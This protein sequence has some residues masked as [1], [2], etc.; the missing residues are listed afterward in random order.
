MKTIILFLISGM[1]I[2]FSCTLRN[3]KQSVVITIDETKNIEPIEKYDIEKKLKLEK[4]L[5]ENNIRKSFSDT[6]LNIDYNC[7]IGQP[8]GTLIN[9]FGKYNGYYFSGDPYGNLGSCYFEYSEGI[10]LRIAPDTLTYL[11]KFNAENKWNIDTFM[12][13]RIKYISII[14][15][16]DVWLYVDN[17]K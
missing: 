4:K 12:M 7:F 16:T 14:K 13:E 8:I 3:D 15:E 6:I 9:K 1:L 5:Y 11:K 10:Q 17:L 2:F